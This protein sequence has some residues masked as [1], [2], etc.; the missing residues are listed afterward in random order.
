MTNINCQ[1]KYLYPSSI[2][3]S[4]NSTNIKT[5]LGS[6]VS[7]CMYDKEKKIGGIN[8]FMLPFWRGDEL[9]SPKF[10]N[11]AMRGLL[12]KILHIGAN[13]ESLVAK[14]FGGAN[15]LNFENDHYRIGIRNIEVAK[16]FLRENMIPVVASDVG[17]DQGR[18]I[19]FNTN[20]GDVYL[21]RIGN[22]PMKLIFEE[23]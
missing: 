14:I 13:R 3:V 8:H 11:L 1:N 7:V 18:K 23:I 16:M 2:I 9:S 12:Q 17:G 5:V 4:S 6:C 21:K 19:L 22:L 15:L 10:G 20:S